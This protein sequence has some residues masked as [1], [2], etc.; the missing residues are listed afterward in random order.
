MT[1]SEILRRLEKATGPSVD[2]DADIYEV[3]G[4]AV[5]RRP[6]RVVG[7][8]RSH[9]TRSWVYQDRQTNRWIAM[10]RL[11]A[12]LDASI[13]LVEKMLPGWGWNVHSQNGEHDATTWTPNKTAAPSHYQVAGPTPAIAILIALFRSLPE[14]SSHEG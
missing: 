3:L 5:K 10:D 2:L 9:Y 7:A 11:S 6:E 8:Y 14:D 4:H 12:S 13:A 1:R